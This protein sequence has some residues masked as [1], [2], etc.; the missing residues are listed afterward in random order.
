MVGS[1]GSCMFF[2][3]SIIYTTQKNVLRRTLPT[4]SPLPRGED[5]EPGLHFLVGMPRPHPGSFRDTVSLKS[6]YCRLPLR[7]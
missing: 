3:D 4:A 1:D 5:L 6:P 7:S 2:E